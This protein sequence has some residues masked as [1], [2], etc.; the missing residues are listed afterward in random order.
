MD[1]ERGSAFLPLGAAG[2]VG[3]A[4]ALA[5]RRRRI[6]FLSHALA[7]V[8]T[9]VFASAALAAP[10]W[11]LTLSVAGA[12]VVSFTG[13]VWSTTVCD[14][15]CRSVS[16]YSDE[17]STLR[18]G[19]LIAGGFLIGVII[20]SVWN[21]VRA[22]WAA[23]LARVAATGGPKSAA[24]TAGLVWRLLWRDTYSAIL[25]FSA[26][27]VFGSQVVSWRQQYIS[28]SG[29]SPLVSQ[30]FTFVAGLPLAIIAGLEAAAA[31]VMLA[32]VASRARRARRAAAA[33]AGGAGAVPTAPDESA[34]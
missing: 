23:R 5:A 3:S 12:Q 28:S 9:I 10:W 8:V 16:A 7:S 25:A 19:Q 20:A 32:V 15:T 29:L 13:Y 18:T 6:V 34:F 11:T 30:D 31:G 26:A 24:L 2:G 4:E 17:E 33:A 21:I 22:L 27:G 14:P 1:P